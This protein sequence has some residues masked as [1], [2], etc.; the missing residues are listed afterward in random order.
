MD[1]LATFGPPASADDPVWDGDG[2][3]RFEEVETVDPPRPTTLDSLFAACVREPRD[4]TAVG[5]LADALAEDLP[6]EW[7]SR[8]AGEYGR[9]WIMFSGWPSG[10][11]ATV[12]WGTHYRFEI[13]LDPANFVP[14]FVAWWVRDVAHT[15]IGR[16]G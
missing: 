16:T 3:E 8:R 11:A 7:E 15:T 5:L 6:G 14:D 13:F 12:C 9:A 4:L 1:P 10:Y 2:T